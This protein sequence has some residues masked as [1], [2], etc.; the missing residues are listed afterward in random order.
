MQKN[1][2]HAIL[3]RQRHKEVVDRLTQDHKGT[4]IQYY[5]DGTLSI[6]DN[7]LDA[8][9]CALSIQL[10]F[11]NPPQVP[12]RIGIN[13]GDILLGPDGIYGDSVNIA[14]R[15]ERICVPGSV[16]ISSR[17]Y[18]Q[19]KN[20]DSI[21]TKDL[22]AFELKN[23]RSP[24]HIH[25][26]IHEGINVPEPQDL[27]GKLGYKEKTV[28]VLPFYNLSQDP[29]DDFFSDGITEQII[30]SLSEL[31]GIR[32]TSRTS[33]FTFKEKQIHLRQLH[34]DM[35]ID[36]VLEGSVRRHGKKVR[37]TAQLINAADDFHLWSETYTREVDD[38]FQ[39]QDD[40]A[41]KIS[42]KLK[43]GFQQSYEK[44]I[45]IPDEDSNTNSEVYEYYHKGRY[46]WKQKNQG[47]V[48]RA[49][50]NF[51]KSTEE[52]SSFYLAWP[53]LARAYAFKC[54]YN[55]MLP[56]EAARLSED[57]MDEAKR[58]DP[59][60]P[61]T[62]NGLA[63]HHLFFTWDWQSVQCHVEQAGKIHER[64]EFILN[65]SIL[66]TSGLYHLVQK[67]H[68][69]AVS[70][71]RKA[72]KLDPINPSLQ[73]ELARAYVFQRTPD[74]ALE[75]INSLIRARPDYT[76]AYE[77]LGW[78][79]FTIG[80]Q[81]EGIQAFEKFKK[82]SAFPLAGLSGL[83]YAFART[84]RIKEAAKM[85]NLIEAVSQDLPGSLVHMD[86]A[87]AHLGAQEYDEMFD[88][89][90]LALLARMPALI[91]LE[92]NPL[93]DEIRRFNSYKEIKKAIYG[94]DD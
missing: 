79:L 44:R 25:A 89:L 32:V 65:N 72:C 57:C 1:E 55:Q 27:A 2:D 3:L 69:T 29:G 50:A 22:G 48:D 85:K 73:L 4:I 68:D 23:V 31:E 64:G 62:Q 17:V 75:V 67:Q 82:L 18:D 90:H 38:V 19:I 45:T 39:L 15:I 42:N 14:S 78:I 8:I 83:A 63:L 24:M 13:A 77:M 43:A 84:S 88:Q 71:L 6:F 10:E 92:T 12:L 16:L 40:I 56:S 76:P 21:R 58:L 87:I 33:S 81:R 7:S 93:W 20:N 34:Q 70:L 37:I 41:C 91:F 80:S 66:H 49:I 53:A 5:G 28:M 9:Q 47:F 30:S 59:D 94:N 61:R 35:G 36:H 11:Q 74:K 52:D 60:N 54:F 86:L 51:R 26:V 46:E